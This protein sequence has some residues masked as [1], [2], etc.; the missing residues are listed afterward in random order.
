[1]KTKKKSKI[2]LPSVTKINPNA[3]NHML[4]A[5]K[6]APR[7]D[8]VY[9]EH[10]APHIYAQRSNEARW[11]IN[12]MQAAFRLRFTPA[13][14]TTLVE[15]HVAMGIQITKNQKLKQPGKTDSPAKPCRGTI[16]DIE[17]QAERIREALMAD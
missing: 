6:S 14:I 15:Y 4:K 13:D 5:T 8:E 10:L 1:M 16:A 7:V 12:D 3:R 11:V 17:A 2:P 9:P